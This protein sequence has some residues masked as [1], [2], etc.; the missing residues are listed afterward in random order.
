[1]LTAVGLSLFSFVML[2]TTNAGNRDF[3]SYW[4]AG[5][6]LVRH[7]NPYDSAAVF[8]IQKAAG[9]TMG[10]AQ[11]L[12]NPPSALFLVL[13]LGLVPARLGS[14]LWSLALVAAT[15]VSIR[16]LWAIHGRPRDRLHL[17]GY[18]F[19][20]ASACMTLGQ[21]S[22]LAL[23]GLVLF[24]RY[25][26]TRPFAAG[27]ALA[28]LAIKPH[29]VLPFGL[30]LLL[31]VFHRRSY[32]VLL[33]AVSGSACALIPALYFDPLIFAHYLPVLTQANTESTL[34]PTFSALVRHALL[35]GAV[36]PQ[37]V[38]LTLGCIWAVAYFLRNG[39]VWDWNTHGARVVLV[40]VWVAPYLWFTDE[41]VVLP[42]I[43][44]GIYKSTNRSLITFGIVDG[45]AVVAVIAGV[46]MGS[47]F[48]VWTGTAWLLW[49]L[50]AVGAKEPALSSVVNNRM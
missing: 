42:A 10:E 22:I 25:H 13:P 45:I 33:G 30:V 46:S 31:W 40:S 29:L 17:L 11:L 6:L 26:R 38:P 48:F 27:A 43:L 24:L 49:Y 23:L 4:S 12:R 5:Q 14:V 19:A 34:M 9:S 41:I 36:W 32:S 15:I 39:K 2:E 28:L 44:R 50:Y 21:A 37:F 18:L 3:I 8:R 16:L 7:A 35:P 20:P 47:G 1:M